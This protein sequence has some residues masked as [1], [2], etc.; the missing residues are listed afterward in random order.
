M[1]DFEKKYYELVN[2]SDK[3]ADVKRKE[4]ILKS[5]LENKCSDFVKKYNNNDNVKSL[6]GSIINML[7]RGVDKVQLMKLLSSEEKVKNIF[8]HDIMKTLKNHM[9]GIELSNEL[10]NY[11]TEIIRQLEN[12]FSSLESVEYDISINDLFIV[13]DHS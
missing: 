2:I 7:Q 8:S 6:G 13:K 11:N 5:E 3:I 12:K 4:D 1:K 10:L 9:G